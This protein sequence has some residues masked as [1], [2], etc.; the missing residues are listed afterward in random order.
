MGIWAMGIWAMPEQGLRDRVVGQ[1][2]GHHP[3]PH[4]PPH[5]TPHRPPSALIET[6]RGRYTRLVLVDPCREGAAPLAHFVSPLLGAP[7]ALFTASDV[8]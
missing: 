2:V 6:L 4:H 7:L 3:S 5:T 1:V 8:M